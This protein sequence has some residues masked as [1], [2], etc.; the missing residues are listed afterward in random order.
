MIQYSKDWNKREFNE[1]R[2]PVKECSEED[3]G[4]TEFAISMF[5]TWKG[6]VL[7]CPDLK[8]DEELIF[9]GDESS[10]YSQSVG[11]K[12]EKCIGN[13]CKNNID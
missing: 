4:D 5:A 8:E 11:I 2:Y 3:F 6:F 9:K 10:M 1:T 13:N 12:Y 7:V